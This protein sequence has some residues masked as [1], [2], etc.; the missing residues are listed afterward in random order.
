[1]KDYVKVALDYDN[2]QTEKFLVKR[3][4]YFLLV[5]LTVAALMGIKRQEP[6]YSGSSNMGGD[7]LLIKNSLDAP[8]LSAEEAIKKMHVES[9]FSVKLVAAEPLLAAPVALNFDDKGRMWVV[10]MENYMPDTSGTGEDEPNGKVVILSDKNGDGKMDDRK[11]FLDSLVLPR[12]ICLIENGILVAESPNLWFYQIQNDRPVRRTLVDATYAE[13]GNVEHQPNGLFRALDNWIYSAKS[14]KRYRKKGNKWLIEKT[15]FRGQWGMTQDD[16]GRLFYNTNSEN[17]LGD[18]FSP[19]LGA[20]NA[21]QRSVAGYIRK[22]V[23]DNRVFPARPT[24]GVNRGYV[25]GVLDDSLRLV[26]FTAAC[27][28]VIY[29]GTLFDKSYYGNAF[30]AEPSANLIKRNI[31]QEDGYKVQGR[32]AYTKKEFLASEDE[33]FRPV[34]LYVGPDGA[35]YIID[36]YRGIIQHKTYLTPYLKNEIRERALTK[37]LSYGRIYKVV[38]ENKNEQAIKISKDPNQLVSLLRSENGWVR[39]KA[40]Q[41]LV[42]G[43]NKTIASALRNQLKAINSPLSVSHSLWTMEGLGI[44]QTTDVLPL[45]KQTDW[46]IRMQALS[47]LPSVMNKMNYR[48]FLPVLQ[49]M[50]DQKDTLAAPYIA[51]LAHFVQRI[52]PVVAHRLLVNLAKK[53]PD[54]L[55]VADAIIS[56]LEDKEAVFYKE[57]LKINPDSNLVINRQLKK[58]MDDIARSRNNRSPAEL[59]KL[60]PKGVALFGTICQ[61]CHGKDGNGVPSLAPPLNNS[62][63][64]VGDKEKLIA[65]VLYGLTGPVRVSGKVYKAPEINGDMPPI[66]HNKEFTDEDI[67]QVLN[68]IRNAWSNKA[69]KVSAGDITNTRNKFKNREKTFTAEELDKLN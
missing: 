24:P 9:G 33:R 45:L 30:V 42:D 1:M 38:P 4:L 5:L 6:I 59:A 35:L 50:I 39:N 61:T 43:K 27:S 63:W 66:G 28:P 69:E 56:N 34:S 8:V 58:I 16:Q 55:F 22:V 11:V 48:F 47:V 23:A 2:K 18:Y 36:M 51:F 62:N 25:P 44:L 67:A 49:K 26:N 64:V 7:S 40:Q 46:K 10:E 32:E 37:P 65:I 12:A 17:L 29:N 15:H 68:Y 57:A 53:Y 14:S 3:I 41:L 20:T 54:N 60:Y 31:L 19:G 21:H 52:N 13:G